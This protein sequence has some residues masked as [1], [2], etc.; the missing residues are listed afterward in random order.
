MSSEGGAGRRKGEQRG[1]RHW[2]GT[3]AK[4]RRREKLWE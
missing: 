1:E 4:E 2:R 3:R